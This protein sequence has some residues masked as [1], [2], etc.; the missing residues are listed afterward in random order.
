[1]PLQKTRKKNKQPLRREF[2]SFLYEMCVVEDKFSLTGA[3]ENTVKCTA[4]RLLVS[5]AYRYQN[6]AIFWS[7][8]ANE[9]F[10]RRI[11][12]NSVRLQSWHRLNPC[13]SAALSMHPMLPSLTRTLAS[14]FHAAG[15][16]KPSAP[17][18]AMERDAGRGTRGRGLVLLNRPPARLQDRASMHAHRLRKTAR[19]GPASS[20]M[21]TRGRLPSTA[22]ILRPHPSL[23][24]RGGKGGLVARR[25][26]FGRA[27]W[28]RAG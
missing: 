9:F 11:V 1:M 7:S 22:A 3:Q 17:A 19:P 25:R 14:L 21:Q 20:C 23:G 4:S 2:F 26:P 13:A 16:R 5:V 18:F 28:G 10:T 12:E 8:N 6:Q 27:G 24:V 15:S